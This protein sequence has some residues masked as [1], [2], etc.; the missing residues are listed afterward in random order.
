MEAKVGEIVYPST[1]ASDSIKQLI[2][3]MS[4]GNFEIKADIPE[5]DIAKVRIGNEARVTLDAYGSDI[6][7][8]AKVLAVDPAETVIEGIPTYKVTLQFNEQDERVKSGM[9]ANVDIMTDKR[10]NVITI[11][12][13]AVIGKNGDKVVR[14]LKTV[15]NPENSDKTI[16][17]VEEI[18]VEVGIRGSD[19]QIEVLSGL[20]EGDKIVVSIK[21]QK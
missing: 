10:E 3:I 17:M 21:N 16:E 1:S 19:G 6:E 2:S 18:P 12:Q 14:L 4:E 13:R 9:T 11:P 7:F 5:V 20:N 15:P 8:N